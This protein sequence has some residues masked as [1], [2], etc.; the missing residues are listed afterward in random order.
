MPPWSDLAVLLAIIV[1]TG[2]WVRLLRRRGLRG[3]GLAL[4]SAVAFLGLVLIVTMTAHCLDVLSRLAIGTGYD[5]LAFVYNFRVYSLLL[6]GVVLIACGL[7]LMR[8][9][10]VIGARTPEIRGQAVGAV[11]TV[12]ILVAPL[13]PVQGFFA[14]PLTALSAGLLVLV[15]WRVRPVGVGAEPALGA[16]GPEAQWLE[17]PPGASS[18][19]V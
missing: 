3:G 14:I 5:G 11:A 2:Y 8:I 19:A 7:R 16:D 9:S 17:R 13:I 10:L 12:L 18:S 4:S 6:L 1:S 15:L